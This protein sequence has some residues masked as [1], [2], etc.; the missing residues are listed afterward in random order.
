MVAKK[1][2]P[3]KRQQKWTADCRAEQNDINW[4]NTYMLACNCTK[5]TKLSL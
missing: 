1:R 5:S 2:A 3:T 4:S